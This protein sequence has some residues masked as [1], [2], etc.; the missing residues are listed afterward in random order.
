M[1]K[2]K[3]FINMITNVVIDIIGSV[4]VLNA[5]YG[6]VAFLLFQMLMFDWVCCVPVLLE[7][8]CTES[9]ESKVKYNKGCLIL[10]VIG[11]IV[12][13][14]G[15]MGFPFMIEVPAVGWVLGGIGIANTLLLTIVFAR[16]VS[17]LKRLLTLENTLKNIHDEEKELVSKK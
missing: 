6:F 14:I 7:D 8:C 3:F 11:I 9:V 2:F 12:T 15:T 16:K 10:C 1:G 13:I 4:M 17:L 5:D